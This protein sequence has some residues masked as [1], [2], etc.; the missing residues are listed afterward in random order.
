MICGLSFPAWQD[1][2]LATPSSEEPVTQIDADVPVEPLTLQ[3]DATNLEMELQAYER[4]LAVTPFG[5]PEIVPDWQDSHAMSAYVPPSCLGRWVRTDLGVR[6]FQGLGKNS[7]NREQVVRRITRDVHTRRILESLPCEVH[8]QVPL[9]RKCLPGCGPTTCHTRDIETTLCIVFMPPLC[10]PMPPIVVRLLPLFLR[11]GGGGSPSF[12][13]LLLQGGQVLL[14]FRC[15]SHLPFQTLGTSVRSNLGTQTLMSMRKFLEDA[16][17][18]SKKETSKET[19][20]CDAELKVKNPVCTGEQE[21]QMED[22]KSLNVAQEEDDKPP[23]V[24][25]KGPQNVDKEVLRAF[26]A[27]FDEFEGRIQCQEEELEGSAS[28]TEEFSSEPVVQ[29]AN[30]H[31]CQ[32]EDDIDDWIPRKE[33]LLYLCDDWI[34]PIEVMRKLRKI[35]RIRVWLHH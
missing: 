16:E 21:A 15:G 34:Q 19:S 29:V 3:A 30:V 31:S 14:L 20:G 1:M 17:Q 6:T 22:D 11:G 26:R 13:S 7:P 10:F 4:P 27:L 28:E 9:H 35:A 12:S 25:Q 18:S 32:D 23:N 8:L 2:E 33:P 5:T 24:S